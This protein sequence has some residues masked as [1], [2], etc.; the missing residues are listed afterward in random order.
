M[1]I[2]EYM[3]SIFYLLF[4]IISSNKIIKNMDFPS[5]KNCI[6]YKP[7]LM[8]RDFT[9]SLNKCEKFGVKDI[10]TDKI[11]YNYADSCRNDETKCG[12]EG[13]YFEEEKNINLKLIKH[14]IVTNI[15]Y[16]LIVFIFLQRGLF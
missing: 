11:T 12:I 3:K 7:N 8:D 9:S 10:I 5:C 1:I 14:N 6:Y 2:V 15:P 4:S 13:K 16:I